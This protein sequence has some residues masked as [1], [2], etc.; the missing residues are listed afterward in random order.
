IV[1]VGTPGAN[2]NSLTQNNNAELVNATFNVPGYSSVA[3]WRTFRFDFTA[4]SATTRVS[5]PH[6]YKGSGQNA[7]NVD[8]VVFSSTAVNVNEGSTATTTGTFHS[9]GPG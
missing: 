1:Q 7:I 9:A 6:L 5:F 2:A 8:A 3:D 4:V